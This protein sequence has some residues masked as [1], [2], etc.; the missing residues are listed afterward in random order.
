MNK[1]VSYCFLFFVV[2]MF[3]QTNIYDISRSGDLEALKNIY[4]QS[5]ELINTTNNKGYSPLVLATYHGHTDAVDFLLDHGAEAN[6]NSLYGT[7]LMAAVVKGYYE[8]SER[9]LQSDVDVNG[10]DQN[11]TTALHYAVMYKNYNLT[12]LLVLYKAN[13]LIKDNRGVTPLDYANMYK[14]K[15]LQ[16]L[17]TKI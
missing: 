6:T 3:S 14:D 17:L 10:S 4:K 9:I 2:P 1:L 12:K 5:P 7:P 11:G 16:N 15:E 8:I 13:P